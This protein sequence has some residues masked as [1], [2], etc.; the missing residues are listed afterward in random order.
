MNLLDKIIITTSM[1]KDELKRYNM[2]LWI[3]LEYI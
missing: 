3:K 1:D 2:F